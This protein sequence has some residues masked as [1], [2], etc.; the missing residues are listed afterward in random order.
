M[1]TQV[2]QPHRVS[3]ASAERAV[4][5]AIQGTRYDVLCWHSRHAAC[6]WVNGAI[7]HTYNLRVASDFSYPYTPIRWH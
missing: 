5:A 1:N 3:F 7:A 2:V 6:H 4:C